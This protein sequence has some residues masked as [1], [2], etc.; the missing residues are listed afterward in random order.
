VIDLLYGYFEITAEDDGRRRR[1]KI[2]GKLLDLDRAL[3]DTV[4]YL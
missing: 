1:Q 2:L 4:P 3:E